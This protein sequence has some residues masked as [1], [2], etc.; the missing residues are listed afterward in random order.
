[1]E[2]LLQFVG[3]ISD[4]IG[5]VFSRETH[6]EDILFPKSKLMLDV[7][8]HLGSGCGCQ[9]KN[10]DVGLDLP[11]VGNMKVRGAEIVP[12]LADAVGF[13]NGDETHPHVAEF[14]LEKL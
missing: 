1:M 14:C 10:G 5:Q 2:E 7:L 3:G 4:D 12:P 11:Y 8:H 13:I 6:A 9:S